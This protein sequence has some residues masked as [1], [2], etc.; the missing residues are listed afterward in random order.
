VKR[1][2]I[3]KYT[4]ILLSG[5]FIVNLFQ[6]LTSYA[7]SSSKLPVMA[8]DDSLDPFM[9]MVTGEEWKDM[10]YWFKDVPI[11]HANRPVKG[12][13]YTVNSAHENV[14]G[15]DYMNDMNWVIDIQGFNHRTARPLNKSVGWMPLF[16]PL[17]D[18]S[19]GRL[20]VDPTRLSYWTGQ[21]NGDEGYVKSQIKRSPTTV[22]DN[23]NPQKNVER[24]YIRDL[25]QWSGATHELVPTG[26]RDTAMGNELSR[27]VITTTSAPN[28]I[29]N[30]PSSV[31]VGETVSI[32]YEGKQFYPEEAYAA[33]KFISFDLKVDGKSI[34]ST[35]RE[36]KSFNYTKEFTFAEEKSYKLDLTVTDLIGRSQTVS[37]TVVAGK[38][39]TEPPAE[40]V[41]NIPPHAEVSTLPFYYWPE[42]VGISTI[43]YDED[44]EIV[45]EKWSVDGE[46]SGQTWNSPRVTE[47][48]PHSVE[49]QNEDD[50]GATGEA[51]ANFDILPTTPTAK[52]T[53][54]GELKQN[55]AVVFDAKASDLVSPIRVA[56]IDYSKTS[57]EIVPKSAGLT[58]NDI[59]VR[60][61]SDPSLRQVLF[62]KP[63][64]YELR[65]SVT[66]KYDETSEVLIEDI[67]IRP[68]EV[69]VSAFTVDKSVY[70]RSETDSKQATV[71]LTDNS[72][73]L[74]GDTIQER[75]W[76]VEFDANNDGVFGSAA[77]GG[78]QV[79]ATGNKKTVTYK[80]KHVGHYRFSLDVKE[81]FGEATY[82]EFIQPEEYLKDNSDVLDVGGAVATYM[83]PENFNLPLTDKSIKIDNVPP[84]IDFAVKRKNDIHIVLDFGGMDIAALQRK[85]GARAGG[86]VNN[87]GGGGQFNHY[88]YQVDESAKNKLTAYAGSLE[89]DLRFKGLDA[90]V[91]INNCYFREMDLDGECVTNVPVYG[92]VDYG[93][94]SYSS[95]SGTSP[96]SGS[97]EVVSQSS[98][99]I[100]T[101]VAVWCYQRTWYD[102][103]VSPTYPDGGFWVEQSHAPPCGSSSNT[104]YEMQQTGTR[105]DASIRKW[106]SNNQFVVTHY[107]NQGCG[108]ENRPGDPVSDPSGIDEKID[109][110][111]FTQQFSAYQFNNASYKY[112]F[113]MDQN[114]WS[115]RSNSTKR[116]QV[117]N[118]IENSNV[119]LWNNSHS[120]LRLDA[121][122][123]TNS[124][125]KQ[126]KYSQFNTSS[127]Q[128]N[129]QMLRDE[130]LNKF[131]IEENAESFTIVLGDEIDYTTVYDDYE[132][133]PE[134]QR[135][136]KF[137]HDP[138]SVNGRV[139]DGQPIGPIAQSG[140]YVSHPMQLNEVGTYSVTLRAKDNPLS[141][142]GNDARFADYQ[143][144]SDEEI[145]REYKVNV[146]RRPIAD[147]KPT[148]EAGTLK[149]TLDPSLSFDPD[150]K[151]NW[152]ILGIAE[153]GIT[154]YNWEKYVLD[155]VEYVGKPPV[156]LQPFKDY[157]VTLQVKDID[158][159]YGTI[160]KLV[161]TKDVNLKPVALFDSPSVVLRGNP[162]NVETTQYFIRD[163]SY[164]PNG[165]PLTNYNWTVKRQSDGVVVWSGANAPTS[166]LNMGL[167][168]GRYLIGLQVWDIPKYPPSLQS[169][170]Y[171]KEITVLDNN[172]PNSCFELSRTPITVAS[173]PCVDEATSPYTIHIDESAIYTDKSSDPD[174][175]SLINYSWIVE[176]LD[177]SNNVLRTW[178]TGSAPKDFN[179]FGGI[180][181]YRITQIV[182]DNPPAPLPSLSGRYTRIFNVIQGPQAP[183]AV[184]EYNPLMPIQGNAIQLTDKSVDLD[185]TVVQWEWSIV[186]PNGTT[187]IQ[188]SQNPSIS[189]ANVGTYK[190]TLNV[191]DNTS[192]TRLKSKEP[193]YKE[194]VVA[195]APPNLP[196]VPLF[197]WNPFKPFLGESLALN[198]DSSYDVDGSIVSYNWQIRSKEGVVTNSTVKNPTLTAASEYYDATLTVRDDDGAT[199]SVTQRINVNIARLIPLVTHT[200]EWKKYW[201]LEGYDEDVN[202]FLAGEQ[203]VIR[204][205]T[206]P[207]NR[208]EGEVNFGGNIGNVQIPSTS[209]NLVST[210]AYEYVWEAVL[211]RDDFEN[212][213]PGEYAFEFTGYH[214]VN[215]PTVL[216]EGVYLIE[217]TGSVYEILGFH[218][219][220]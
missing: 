101:N 51:F 25:L 93:S 66:N 182:F 119:F 138:T 22:I 219:N 90:K 168:T 28:A 45:S 54:N 190:V 95:Y 204:L 123:L 6:P 125:G 81:A 215:S 57:W 161:S 127:L 217:I 108:V 175:H 96:Y 5:F 121:Q 80:S 48:T 12:K 200:P 42:T 180:G 67:V 37:R 148:I 149:L 104:Q 214:P 34:V 62:K 220:Y 43:S 209:F 205:F 208:V 7:N 77:D 132:K 63:G 143:K 65:L 21:F 193:A 203:F 8:K 207:A 167:P 154:E 46:E 31:K 73:S 131:L 17:S 144:W 79:I 109:T 206:T 211:W 145:V 216:S 122:L 74:D 106:Q 84:V 139:I 210:S 197:V 91:D 98:T 4:A 29:I 162:L 87:G 169:D 41:P 213:K 130:M 178:N 64:T 150:H 70:L 16:R 38:A 173:I 115:W 105:Y 55:R 166:F 68:D 170:L 117:T 82:E 88:Y 35:Y 59:K 156:T 111:D 163:R 94:Y 164:D 129:I 78:K 110:S 126:G 136:W 15:T 141:K 120:N 151:N 135:E 20:F 187:T 165:D 195:P 134:L 83:Q 189:N 33:R 133:D 76:Y 192:P 114:I 186:A 128:S 188:T 24:V 36:A 196:P 177:A 49:F 30:V 92:W 171:E 185:G 102:R 181:K 201:T 85:T 75:I 159:A 10:F 99:P 18:G 158:G 23:A 147:F 89:A 146:H 153:R 13:V 184:F 9:Q 194:I 157:Y 118:K 191:W 27:I 174:G 72:A 155:G 183:F 50:K 100:Y 47:K 53:L 52:Y 32:A 61:S 60:P 212:I 140:L 3:R 142:V 69:P 107:V 103:P 26:I 112:Y 19:G 152:S 116:N 56:P 218:R 58:G 176:K 40:E 39:V 202:T 14:S 172:P 113:R 71:T 199:A 2:K 11:D 160:T 44:G 198:S 179:Q 137:V 1:R 86:G 124:S 97:W